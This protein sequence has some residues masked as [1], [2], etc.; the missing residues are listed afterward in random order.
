MMQESIERLRKE[1]QENIEQL[2]KEM[3]ENIE[4]LR[5]EIEQLRKE[6]VEIRQDMKA[7]DT[8]LRVEIHRVENAI[9][10][11]VVGLLIMQTGVIIT[12]WKLLG[13]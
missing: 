2:R 12:I 3:Q 6:I 7:M 11:W 1:T 5:K 10:R 9:I 13:S 8:A 4:Q